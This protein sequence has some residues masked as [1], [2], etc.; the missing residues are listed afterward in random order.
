MNAGKKRFITY[1]KIRRLSSRE[2]PGTPARIRVAAPPPTAA[3][4]VHLFL[5][6][7][8]ILRSECDFVVLQC[9]S[10]SHHGRAVLGAQHGR[11]DTG[12]HG[13]PY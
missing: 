12:C 4:L 13:N 2:A 10:G 9:N 7:W 3:H 8:L 6:L 11:V 5:Q 1:L